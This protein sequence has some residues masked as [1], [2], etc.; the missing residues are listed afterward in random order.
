MSVR[1][2]KSENWGHTN[3]VGTTDT[4]YLINKQGYKMRY[5]DKITIKHK[6]N[7]DLKVL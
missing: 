4:T 5:L 3:T 7:I 6:L 1:L 2:K